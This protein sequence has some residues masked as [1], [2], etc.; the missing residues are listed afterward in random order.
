MNLLLLGAGASFGA[1]VALG[2]DPL[3]P[4]GHELAAYILRWLDVNDPSNVVGRGAWKQ[5]FPE[6]KDALTTVANQK[7]YT[8]ASTQPFE[9][10]MD[11]WSRSNDHHRICLRIC[12]KLIACSMAGGQLCGFSEQADRLDD[13]LALEKPAAVVTVNYDTLFEEAVQRRSLRYTYIGIPGIHS[14]VYVSPGGGGT[15]IPIF[16]IHGSINWLQARGGAGGPNFEESLRLAEERQDR[17]VRS[18]HIPDASQSFATTVASNRPE[19]LKALDDFSPSGGPVVAVYGPG[20]PFMSNPEHVERHRAACL[21]RLRSTAINRV[22]VIGIRPVCKADDPTL[23]GLIDELNARAVEKV[24]V[25]PSAEDCE[26]F[27]L[28]GFSAERATLAE[29]LERAPPVTV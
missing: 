21:D 23:H 22:V 28:R 19:L 12:Q 5:H 3:P 17:T 25:S 8:S 15:P 9:K 13:L 6:I 18:A 1:R 11:R 7:T 4:L 27:R 10:L 29:F 2:P 24:Y 26:E 14:D 20:K 16:K